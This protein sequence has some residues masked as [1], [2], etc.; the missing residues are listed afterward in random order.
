MVVAYIETV[1]NQGTGVDLE[2]NQ[3]KC[4]ELEVKIMKETITRWQSFADSLQEGER[5]AFYLW[6]IE[7]G[8][9]HVADL[10]QDI[11]ELKQRA[12]DQPGK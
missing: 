9:E 10:E 1:P 3:I 4:L 5:K 6:R 2:E 11:F 12:Y 7:A 8:W